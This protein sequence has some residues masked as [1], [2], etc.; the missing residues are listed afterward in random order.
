MRAFFRP[1]P[2]PALAAAWA[3]LAAGCGGDDAREVAVRVCG[4][5]Q[6]PHEVDA[7]RVR[8]LDE[9][10]AVVSDG[11]DELWPAGADAGPPSANPLCTPDPDAPRIGLDLE[12]RPGA[13]D[14]WIEAIALRDGVEVARSVV[15]TDGSTTAAV[16]GFPAVCLGVG[17]PDG[18]TCIDG[19]CV[20]A[21]VGGAA[22]ACRSPVCRD[23]ADGMSDG[24]VP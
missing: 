2:H 5:L 22:T 10:R 3:A 13:G 24:G 4:E 14:G 7:V 11:V 20:L 17:C 8:V 16:L 23:R 1:L 9:D 6:V 21:P 15:R 18:Q 12:V 19:A